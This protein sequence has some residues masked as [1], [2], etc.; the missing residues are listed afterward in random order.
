MHVGHIMLARTVPEPVG[1]RRRWTR[2]GV[3][4]G[5]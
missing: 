1:H 4:G 3:A 2:L 5:V